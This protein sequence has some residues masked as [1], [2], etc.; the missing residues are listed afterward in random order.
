MLYNPQQKFV[1]L[2]SG[3]MT[4]ILMLL[5][6]M[7]TSVSIVKEKEMGTMEILLVSPMRP[8]LVVLSKAIPYMVLCFIDVVIILLLAVFLLEMPIR[9][10][11]FLLLAESLLFILTTLSLGLLVSSVVDSQQTAMFFHW[12]VF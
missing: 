3:V 2:R 9:G 12:W 4:L 7:M 11:L 1:Q 5:G 10:S 6:A 8:L